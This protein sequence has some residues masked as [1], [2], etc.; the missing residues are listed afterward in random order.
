MCS[1][2]SR[3]VSQDT[4]SHYDILLEKLD[5]RTLC[6]R[7]RRRHYD[8]LLSINVYSGARYCPSL[9]ETLGFRVPARNIVTLPCSV[10]PPATALRLDVLLLLIQFV[11]RQTFLETQFNCK[12]PSP[13]QFLFVCLFVCLLSL[14]L[15]Y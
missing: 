8:A 10:T 12:F 11:N 5:L 6:I 13:I 15:P 1:S 2:L 14:C 4:Q 7:R 9:L 3:H